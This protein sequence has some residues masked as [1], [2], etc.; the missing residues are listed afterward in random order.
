MV[1]KPSRDRPADRAHPRRGRRRGRRTGGCVQRRLR[2]RRDRRRGDLRAPGHRHD[3]LHRLHPGRAADLRGG[4]GDR[5]AGRAGAGRQVARTSSST[6]PTCPPRSSGVSRWRS[7]TAARSA[8]RGRG[9]WC[10]PP[11]RTR[12]WRWPSRPRS[13]TPSATRSTRP[14][15][16]ARWRPRPS[17]Q[18]VVG[19]IER[20]IADGARLVFGGPDAAEGL[21]PRRLRPAD[22][23]RRRRPASAIAQEEIFGP[24][25]TIIPYADEDE[26]VAIANGTAVRPDQRRLSVSRSTRSR[27][28]R[29]LRVGQVDVNAATG[30]RWRPFGG[31]KHSGNGREIRPL[32]AGGVP[33]DEV[34]P[35]LTD[36]PG[37]TRPGPPQDRAGCSGLD[38]PAHHYNRDPSAILGV[39]GT[40]APGSSVALD[41]P[42]AAGTH[43]SET[44]WTA[45]NSPASCAPAGRPSS[46]RTS[47]CPGAPVG[48]PEGSGV[49]KSPR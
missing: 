34:H 47:G 44:P 33:G 9:C 19:Y 27:S 36:Q 18:K 48:A 32:R 37:P 13:S 22:D 6:T 3:L 23:L 41:V 42:A 43:R 25:L 38:R 8:A 30:T 20:G 12:S 26:A 1:F 39:G 16:S 49:R 46:P 10:P 29:R 11:A 28:P 7:A 24:V 14:P 31:Y 4:R 45:P 2:H 35:A 17:R 15:G 5:Q 40:P 21:R